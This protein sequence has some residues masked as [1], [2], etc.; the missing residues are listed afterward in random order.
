MNVIEMTV[1]DQYRVAPLD[2]E[3]LRISRDSHPSTGRE[4]GFRRPAGRTETCHDR[5]RLSPYLYVH[6]RDYY[7]PCRF[8]RPQ[9]LLSCRLRHQLDRRKQYAQIHVPAL[10][11]SL[12]GI[13]E[14]SAE[15][16]QKATE[17]YMAWTKK[18]FVTDAKRL[19]RDPGKVI[20]AQ[21][22]VIRAPPTG[23]T[24]KPRKCL[25]ATTPLRRPI[26]DEAVQRALSHPHLEY[27]GTDRSQASLRN[28]VAPQKQQ[29]CWNTCS[30][31]NRDAS[32][33]T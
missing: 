33:R 28:L 20:R 7:T 18:P 3:I 6:R 12:A 17:K 22:A 32:S 1:R 26:Y 8:F 27:G 29:C 14:L 5:A 10:Q 4:S 13:K 30:G 11:R 9:P 31:T 16:M 21:T 23:R 24:A 15:E 19:E 25:A 2:F